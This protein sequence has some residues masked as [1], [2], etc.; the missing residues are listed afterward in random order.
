MLA[1]ELVVQ[2]PSSSSQQHWQMCSVGVQWNVRGDIDCDTDYHARVGNRA[3]VGG[4]NLGKS[5]S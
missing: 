4:A 3:H 2:F 5:Q 1:L